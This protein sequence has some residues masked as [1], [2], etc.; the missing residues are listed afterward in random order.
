MRLGLGVGAND[1]ETLLRSLPS[2]GLRYRAHDATARTLARWCQGRPEF[3][4]VLH[5]ALAGSPGHA[6]WA[7]LCARDG[8]QA[9]GVRPGCSAWSSMPAMR[10]IAWMRSAMRCACSSSLQLGRPHESGRA[11]RARADAARWPA[12]L[13]QGTVVRF[14]VG[15]EDADDLQADLEQALVSTLGD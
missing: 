15:L 14:S 8:L 7:A 11:L 5:P 10:R 9:R 2:M 6:H 3:V 12:H 1:A 4:Q 13:R